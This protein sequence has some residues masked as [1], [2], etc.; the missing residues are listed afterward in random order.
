MP[1]IKDIATSFPALQEFGM[2]AK[3]IQPVMEDSKL[4][5]DEKRKALSGLTNM[6]SDKTFANSLVVD[7]I[8]KIINMK[9]DVCKEYEDTEAQ[10]EG[11]LSWL[12]RM[13]QYRDKL[14]KEV[15]KHRGQYKLKV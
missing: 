4:G 9:E 12:S 7:Q 5:R 6:L 3:L 15:E 11:I 8:M 1:S 2:M 14:K 13:R 10:V